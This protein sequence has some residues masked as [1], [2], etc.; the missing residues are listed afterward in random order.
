MNS[1]FFLNI[2]WY[3]IGN[4]VKNVI[5]LNLTVVVTTIPLARVT[6]WIFQLF[7]GRL[8]WISNFDTVLELYE[9]GRK[10]CTS[11]TKFHVLIA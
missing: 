2:F 3:L 6:W 4:L 5:R 8:K 9:I 10:I 1:N 7:H 11:S